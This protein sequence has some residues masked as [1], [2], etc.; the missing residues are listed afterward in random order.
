MKVLRHIKDIRPILACSRGCFYGIMLV[1]LAGCLTACGNDDLF[2]V[3]AN[4]DGLGT[5]NVRFIYRNGDREQSGMA[6]ALDGKFSFTGVSKQNTIVDIFTT[7]RILLGSLVAKNGDN[8]ELTMKL[9]EPATFS[10]RGNK[11]SEELSNFLSQNKDIVNNLETDKINAA[12]AEY[13]SKNRNN[14]ASAFLLF[15]HFTSNI[16][17]QLADSLVKI[18]NEEHL[19]ARD[20]VEAFTAS[21]ISQADTVKTLT[22]FS[23]YNL[24]GDSLTQ[25]KFP[26]KKGMILALVGDKTPGSPRDSVTKFF[27]NLNRDHDFE[28]NVIEISIVPDTAEA[29]RVVKDLEPKYTRGWVPAGIAS[30]SLENVRPAEIPWFIVSDSTGNVIYTGSTL[31]NAVEKLPLKRGPV[32]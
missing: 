2:T 27:N 9:N 30:P 22:E 3:Q 21:L 4:I 28:L 20:V 10:A 31:G 13:V 16:D 14:P 7:N 25:V 29:K 18:L 5:Q 11:I 19:P 23:F 26:G 24:K 8:I 6:M 1:L 17:K 12:I 32:K 15:T